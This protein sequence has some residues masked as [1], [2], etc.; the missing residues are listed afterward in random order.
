MLLTFYV[1]FTVLLTGDTCAG[2]S[3]QNRV[4]VYAG[5]DTPITRTAYYGSGTGRSSRVYEYVY[6]PA[7][8]NV[9]AW[10]VLQE[11]EDA[12]RDPDRKASEVPIRCWHSDES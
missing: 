7:P 4:A 3:D 11:T 10:M 1:L 8:E 12:L 2:I 5:P 6:P 9:V